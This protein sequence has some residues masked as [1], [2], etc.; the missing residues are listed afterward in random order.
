MANPRQEEKST[1]GME[2]AARRAGERTA[3]QASRLGQAAAEQT[4]RAGQVAAEAGEQVARASATLFQ[5]NAETLQNTWRFG[6]DMAT[7]VMG[8]STEQLGRSLGLSGEGV[9]QATE[10][11]ARNAQ[12]ILYT[13]T[14]AAKVMGGISQ[15]YLQLVRHQVE[16][17]ID[18]MNELWACRTPQ[19]VAAVQTDL[20]RETVGSVL[21]SSRR[22]AD[23]SL[24]LAD[25]A[26]KQIKQN[27][28]EVRRAA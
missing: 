28:E 23:M 15:E 16:T 21:E 20:V 19:E 2:D 26:G 8:R 22:I 4:T 1:Q 6:L 13:G 5:Q 27:M 10:R 14:T 11:S 17:N 9:Q 3:E 7:T 24:K 25:D 12:T 18:R